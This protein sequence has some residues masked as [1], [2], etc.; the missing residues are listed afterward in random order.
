MICMKCTHNMPN[1]SFDE[2][3]ETAITKDGQDVKI[4]TKNR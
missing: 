2:Y 3:F 1:P 4:D